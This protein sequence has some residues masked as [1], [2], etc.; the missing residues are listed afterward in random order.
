MIRLTGRP[1]Y[2]E[3]RSKV[4]KNIVQLTPIKRKFRSLDSIKGIYPPILLQF[5]ASNEQEQ[6]IEAVDLKKAYVGLRNA[7]NSMG[8]SKRIYVQQ[9][10]GEVHLKKLG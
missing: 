1:R 8:L 5:L 4:V 3:R 10:N 2:R 9:E 7:V 6:N